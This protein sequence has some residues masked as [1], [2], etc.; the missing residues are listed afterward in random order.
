MTLAFV[1]ATGAAAYRAVITT[2]GVTRLDM[3]TEDRS[4][5]NAVG[6][7][8]RNE[9]LARVERWAR[10]HGRTLQVSST[11]PTTPERLEPDALAVL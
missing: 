4:R 1:E 5:G 8:R 3:D 11:L 7:D 2:L 10:L 6:I 9:A